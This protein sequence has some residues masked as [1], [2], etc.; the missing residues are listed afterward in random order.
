MSETLDLINTCEKYVGFRFKIKRSTY[1]IIEFNYH[2]GFI[3][4][5]VSGKDNNSCSNMSVRQLLNML[6]NNEIELF[7]KELC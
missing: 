1:E 2:L 7:R 4:T 6:D 3:Y 5:K